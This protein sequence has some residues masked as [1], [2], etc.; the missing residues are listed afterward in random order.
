M[1]LILWPKKKKET[2]GE[3]K[4]KKRSTKTH[5]TA[6]LIETVHIFAQKLYVVIFPLSFLNPG[7]LRMHRF[8]IF[9]SD[10]KGLYLAIFNTSFQQ[11]K[12]K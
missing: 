6:V 1:T 3:K 8:S 12:K 9:T 11:R 7:K 10:N 4:E 5:K 2:L